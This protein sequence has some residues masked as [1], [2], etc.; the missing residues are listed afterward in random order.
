MEN[1]E[2]DINKYIDLAN[3]ITKGDA[4]NS[5]R[6]QRNIFAR[7]LFI[8]QARKNY[9][10][11]KIANILSLNHATIIHYQK[12]HYDLL[13]FDVEYKEMLHNF[14]LSISNKVNK[15]FYFKKDFKNFLIQM[16]VNLK[17]NDISKDEIIAMY[18]DCVQESLAAL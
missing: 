6:K 5:S 1:R 13:E 10:Y 17:S 11:Q 18:N 2:Q 15:I 8:Q 4:L 9:T 12:K 7:M 14:N 16:N 3:L